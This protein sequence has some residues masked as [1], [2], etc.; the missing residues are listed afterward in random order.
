MMVTLRATLPSD[1]PALQRIA[2]DTQVDTFGAYNTE[3]NMKAYLD[4]AYNRENLRQELDE[5]GSHNYL[6]FVNDRLAGFMRLRVT[7]EVVHLLGTNTIEL[8][9]LYVDKNFHGK[10]VG[11]AMMN[12]ALR[13]ARDKKYDW[14]WL[15]VWERNF[16][17]QEF[18]TRW[19]FERFSEHVFQMGDD[20]QTD[21]LLR[22]RIA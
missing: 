2:I 11:A 12:E 6:A 16:K 5:P 7:D 10:G 17:A 19:G 8:Q 18:Y 4:Q 14:I 3:A 15:G 9:R 20:P 22:K 21:W 1:V 13:L